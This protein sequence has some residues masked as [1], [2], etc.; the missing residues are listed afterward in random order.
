MRLNDANVE[1][2]SELKNALSKAAQVGTVI[3]VRTAKDVP[4]GTLSDILQSCSQ[5]G[6]TKV[7]FESP[8][9][10]GARGY[11]PPGGYEASGFTARAPT[12]LLP[13]QYPSTAATARLAAITSNPAVYPCVKSLS[14]PITE[15]ATYPLRFPI[16]LINAMPPAA[17]APPS[18][19]VG[20]VQNSG[21]HE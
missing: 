13:I 11:E 21:K 3:E 15:G 8:G 5:A 12:T 2:P 4:A 16:E 10:S 1:S 9:G 17:A 20:I 18:I 6:F 7:V 19:A 14:A